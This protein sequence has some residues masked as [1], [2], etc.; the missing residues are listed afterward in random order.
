MSYLQGKKN[1]FSIISGV[2][3]NNIKNNK[4]LNNTLLMDKP[5]QQ[6]FLGVPT[7]LIS[8]TS[9]VADC[10]NDTS[11]NECFNCII[12]SG[13]SPSQMEEDQY[14]KNII[15]IND[16]RN[17][18][19]AGV[20][21]CKITN[22]SLESNL[23]FATGVNINGNDINSSELYNQVVKAFSTVNKNSTNS[24][25]YNWLWALMG[26]T[27]LLIALTNPEEIN[28]V[29]EEIKQTISNM[30]MLYSNTINQLISSSQTMIIQGTGIKVHN[31]SLKSVQDITMTASQTNC[32]DGTCISTNINTITNSLMNSLQSSISSQITKMFTYAYEQNKTLIF[33]T[34]IFIV[35]FIFLYIYL[36]FKRASNKSIK[37]N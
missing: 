3:I 5:S 11:I 1:I 28:N 17:N 27:G 36:I 22:I 12:N 37:T 35:F 19:C 23:I 2:V 14:L 6:V 10:G 7:N 20:C 16:K 9:L 13:I 33:G 31:I 21:T 25:N 30:S 8:S 32:G 34:I 4:S 26:G 29:E 24:K 15:N 18:E